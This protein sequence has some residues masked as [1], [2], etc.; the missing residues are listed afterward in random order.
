MVQQYEPVAFAE[1]VLD[2]DVVEDRQLFA[3][4]FGWLKDLISAC[5]ERR[6]VEHKDNGRH[7][8]S[9]QAEEQYRGKPNHPRPRGEKRKRTP[10]IKVFGPE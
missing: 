8:G 2:V 6:F 10:K 1:F 7:A 4:P 3:G 5:N 9:I